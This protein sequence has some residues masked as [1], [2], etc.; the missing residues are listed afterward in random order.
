MVPR[1]PESDPPKAVTKKADNGVIKP[2]KNSYHKVRKLPNGLLDLEPKGDRYL[3][4]VIPGIYGDREFEFKA[5]RDQLAENPLALLRV[6]RQVYAETSLLPYKLNPFSLDHVSSGLWAQ[7]RLPCQLALLPK[8][9]LVSSNG[10]TF[11]HWED[12]IYRDFFSL[13]PMYWDGF[14]KYGHLFR[15]LKKIVVVVKQSEQAQE[16]GRD[17]RAW[18]NDLA[19]PKWNMREQHQVKMRANLQIDFR[20]VSV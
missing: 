16:A 11:V 3:E 14:A 10:F 18:I 5:C 15:S 2:K 4:L 19:L 17:F 7:Q 9:Y 13:Q 20:G 8:I 12:V 1:K 6:C